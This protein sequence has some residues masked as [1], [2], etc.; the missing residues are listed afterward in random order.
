MSNCYNKFDLNEKTCKFVAKCPQGKIRN[1]NFR[2]VKAPE[3]PQNVLKQRIQKS[4]LNAE[5]RLRGRTQILKNLFKSKS[6]EWLKLEDNNIKEKLA[7]IRKQTVKRGFDDLTKNVNALISQVESYNGP[8]R[9][10]RKPKKKVN[11]SVSLNNFPPRNSKEVNLDDL[12]LNGVEDLRASSVRPSP[13]NSAVNTHR[14]ETVLEGNVTPSM[15]NQVKKYA[16][17]VSKAFQSINMNK[18]NQMLGKKTRTK[19]TLK[20]RRKPKGTS[21]NRKPRTKRM[22]SSPSPSPSP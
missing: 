10:T 2:C 19:G 1:E 21:M 14:L 20:E 6:D 11:S 16:E 17:S 5:E 3:N 9:R 7:R 12:D 13:E 4:K 22:R 18:L 8:R 15:N